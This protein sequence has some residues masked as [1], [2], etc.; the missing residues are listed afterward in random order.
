[1][2]K[3]MLMW[4]FPT[5]QCIFHSGPVSDPSRISSGESEDG[6]F[7]ISALKTV[8]EYVLTI[9]ESGDDAL[10]QRY[11]SKT[12]CSFPVFIYK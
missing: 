5:N 10:C 3:I 7:E 1:V 4:S 12:V 6:T 11:E 8:G 9:E 2:R